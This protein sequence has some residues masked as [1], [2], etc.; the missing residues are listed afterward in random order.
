MEGDISTN[1]NTVLLSVKYFFCKVDEY[2][3]YFNF[4]SSSASAQHS[5]GKDQEKINESIGELEG[6]L[7]S[8]SS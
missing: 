3:C 7:K 5:K 8:H 6:R 1:C 2:F 4:S